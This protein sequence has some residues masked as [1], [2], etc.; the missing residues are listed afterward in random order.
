MSERRGGYASGVLWALLSVGAGILI[1]QPP[2]ANANAATI[3]AYFGDNHNHIIIA[4]AISALSALLF[5]PFLVSLTD[6][7]DD[8]SA[9]HVGRVAGTVV[10][11]A[12]LLAGVLQVGLARSAASI[13]ASST[14]LFAYAVDRAIFF[15]VPPLAISVVLVAAFIGLR[16]ASSPR[17][18]GMSAGALGV[19]ALVGGV[20]GMLSTAKVTAAFG[21]AGFLLTILWVGSTSIALWLSAGA[22]HPVAVKEVSA[23]SH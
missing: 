3:A 12:G 22:T 7:F 6:R 16:R 5:I 4:S 8:P 20:G 18:I 13:G 2:A 21:F 14:M 15:V 19:V 1:P 9:A 11:T 17:W 10:I 23:A